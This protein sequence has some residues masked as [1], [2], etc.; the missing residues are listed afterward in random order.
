[1]IKKLRDC[2]PDI[3]D[4]IL[5]D[6]CHLCSRVPVYFIHDNKV[7]WSKDETYIESE[8]SILC[9]RCARN[10]LKDLKSIFDPPKLKRKNIKIDTP[11][12]RIKI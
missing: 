8:Y 9:E 7:T 11:K 6:E 2:D 10:L 4:H 5:G 3:Q 12:R 1:M